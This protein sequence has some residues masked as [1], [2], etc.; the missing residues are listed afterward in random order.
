MPVHTEVLRLDVVES[1]IVRRI[2]RF[3]VE[4]DLEG[5]RIKTHLTNTGRLT[6]VIV[7]G[8]KA[9]IAKTKSRKLDYRLIAVEDLDGKYCIVDVLTQN[10]A[11]ENAVKSRMIPYLEDCQL[12][13]RN[14][15]MLSSIFDFY[16]SCNDEDLIVET[17]SAVMR[18]PSGE[19]M[20]PD[21]IS[22]RGRRHLSD[23]IRLFSNGYRVMIIFIAALYKPTYFKPSDKDP[24]IADLIRKAK[25]LGMELRAVSMHMEHNGAVA[26]SNSD[27]PV[28]LSSPSLIKTSERCPI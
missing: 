24:V 22:I 8:K 25:S 9:L 19:A 20:Y 4:V 23:L 16:F 13:K 28:C 27:V 10:N 11:F 12:V 1:I 21:T 6:D 15:R 17:K 2:N 5:K 7:S 14:I 18:G 26:L 3:V